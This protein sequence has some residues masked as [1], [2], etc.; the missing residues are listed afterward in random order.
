MGF[1][2]VSGSLPHQRPP[3]FFFS[4]PSPFFFSF[5]HTSMYD[6]ALPKGQ[7]RGVKQHLPSD[8]RRW[9][10]VSSVIFINIYIVI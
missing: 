2:F 7:D 1:A 5:T 10:S 3:F 8:K 6:P 4:F 9:M